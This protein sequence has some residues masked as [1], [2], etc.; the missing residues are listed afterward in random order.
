ME[1]FEILLNFMKFSL[2][3][4]KLILKISGKT[5]EPEW[6]QG[7]LLQASNKSLMQHHYVGSRFPEHE[8]FSESAEIICVVKGFIASASHL[9]SLSFS[10]LVCKMC[11]VTAPA[12]RVVLGI[13]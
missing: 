7:M 4:L 2:V 13:K 1:D 8:A 9:S 11:I 6:G 10:F 3:L 12:P 5:G